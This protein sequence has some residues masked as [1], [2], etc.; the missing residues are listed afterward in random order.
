LFQFFV[1]G[2][3]FRLVCLSYLFSFLRHAHPSV[4]YDDRRQQL[5]LLSLRHHSIPPVSDVHS[6]V[7][8]VVKLV[9]GSAGGGLFKVFPVFRGWVHYI[10]RRSKP[11]AEAEPPT[12]H[13][14][15]CVSL[16]SR[17]TGCMVSRL[18]SLTPLKITWYYL[19][20]FSI[21]LHLIASLSV[22]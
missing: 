10:T 9:I 4:G 19:F 11:I 14:N 2:V 8:S 1:S 7:S 22:A 21:C 3:I 5:Q 18:W 15:H 16:T 13:F 6:V 17:K 20:A 12:R